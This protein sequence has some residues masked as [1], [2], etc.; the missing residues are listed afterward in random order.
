MA[1]SDIPESNNRNKL[2]YQQINFATL[3][4]INSKSQKTNNNQSPKF[5]QFKQNTNTHLSL[6][7]RNVFVLY[8][9]NLFIV[10]YLKFV[11]CYL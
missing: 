6:Y 7:N 3:V 2:L 5:K 10:I 4:N 11:F 1:D 9:E 8:F